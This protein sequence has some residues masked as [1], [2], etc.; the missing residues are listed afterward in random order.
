MSINVIL[1]IVFIMFI[2]VI[3]EPFLMYLAYCKGKDYGIQLEDQHNDFLIH[4]KMCRISELTR[5]VEDYRHSLAEAE[6]III[7]M[8]EDDKDPNI[9]TDCRNYIPV[10]RIFEED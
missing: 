9:C 5:E 7:K 3:F 2:V 10:Q 1:N 6:D 4:S 8:K